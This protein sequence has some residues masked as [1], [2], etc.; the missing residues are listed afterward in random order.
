M[1]R[2]TARVIV[3]LASV[4]VL[5]WLAVMERDARLRAR[6]VAAAGQGGF[7]RAEADLRAARFLN[8]DT[9][10]DVER[11]VMYVGAGRAVEGVALFE[12]VVRREPENRTAWALLYGFTQRRDAATAARALSALRRLDP[13]VTRPR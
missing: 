2:V 1:S 7:E 12:S 5:A 4:A 11:A 10:P 8:P 13:L 6:G 9:G 3:V